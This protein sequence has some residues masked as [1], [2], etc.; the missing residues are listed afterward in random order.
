M[1][2]PDIWNQ[3]RNIKQKHKTNEVVVEVTTITTEPLPESFKQRLP[4]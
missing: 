2:N 4:K 3:L 1:N